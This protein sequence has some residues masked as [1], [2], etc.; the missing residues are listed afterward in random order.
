MREYQGSDDDAQEKPRSALRVAETCPL[1]RAPLVLV[2]MEE[3]D[4]HRL[5]VRCSDPRCD[6]S[7]PHDA[8]SVRLI[9]RVLFLCKQVSRLDPN[10]ELWE[11]EP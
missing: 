10:A 5:E 3:L 6:F 9:E 8:R 4:R 2:E 1:C 7:E 11:P